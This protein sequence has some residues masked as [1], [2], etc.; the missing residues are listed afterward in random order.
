MVKKLPLL[1][2]V[3]APY[4]V[5]VQSRAG[6]IG[7]LLKDLFGNNG[8][9]GKDKKD[10]KDKDKDNVPSQPTASTSNSVPLN[11]GVVFLMLAGIGLGAK[12]IYDAKAQKKVASDIGQ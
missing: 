5:P 9:N 8:N 7:D 11:G 12:L 2:L 6:V 3:A 10:K 1:L 4:F